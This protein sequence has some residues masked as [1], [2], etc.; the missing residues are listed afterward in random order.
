MN[1][2]PSA[3]GEFSHQAVYYRA[4]DGYLAAVMPF[5][6]DGLARSEPILAAVPPPGAGLLRAGLGTDGAGVTFAD[7]IELGRNPGRIISAVWEFIGRHPGQPVRF[8]GEPFWPARSAAEAREAVRHEALINLA[9]SAAPVAVLCPYDA[10]GLAPAIVASA[11]CTHPVIGTEA[12]WRPSPDY[13]RGQVPG[14]AARP[15]AR[16]PARAERL[17]YRGDLRPVRDFVTGFA[18]RSGLNADRAADLVLAVGEVA[19]NTLRHTCGGGVVQAWREPGEVICQV[20][21]QGQ[22]SDPLVGRRRPPDATGLGVWVVHQVCDL[23][24][25]RTGRGGTAVRMHLRT[26]AG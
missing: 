8:L 23:V 6:R 25:L 16:P 5:I 9:F 14:A 21:D 1:W 24:E 13:A 12:G 26:S 7:M 18:Q 22:I 2:G 11:G 3:G 20:S 10:A 17:A 19:A 4:L 15:L